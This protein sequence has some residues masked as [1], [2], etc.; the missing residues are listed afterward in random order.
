MGLQSSITYRPLIKVPTAFQFWISFAISNSA[1]CAGTVFSILISRINVFSM[2]SGETHILYFH[3]IQLVMKYWGSLD[4]SMVYPLDLNLPSS[5]VL[6]WGAGRSV[7]TSSCGSLVRKTTSPKGLNEPSPLS[8]HIGVASTNSPLKHKR[9]SHCCCCIHNGCRKGPPTPTVWVKPLTSLSIE[10]EKC[11][12]YF[13]LL[14][15]LTKMGYVVPGLQ[16]WSGM[17]AM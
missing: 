5:Y 6:G 8:C 1:T 13:W 11:P 4:L 15:S 3:S 2:A 12:K 17:D 14:S 10:V 9:G 7:T 16:W